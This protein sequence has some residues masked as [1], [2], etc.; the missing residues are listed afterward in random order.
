MLAGRRV[1]LRAVEPSDVPALRAWLADPTLWQLTREEPVAPTPLAEAERA[2]TGSD[3]TSASFAV[4]VDGRL[5][6]ACSL[7]GI[8]LHN[9]T[10]GVGLWLGDPATRGQGYGAEVVALLVDYGFRL[11]GLHRLEIETLATNTAMRAL[12]ERAG[13]APAGTSR[14]AAWVDGAFVDVV[15][16]DLLVGDPAARDRRSE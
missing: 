9:R 7:H 12:A 2:R 4:E 5:V 1:L 16:Y 11:R 8:D 3:P 13:F 6:G 10:A 15:H 14:E